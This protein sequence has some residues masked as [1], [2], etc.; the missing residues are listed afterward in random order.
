MR[1]EINSKEK[2]RTAIADCTFHPQLLQETCFK[3]DK[4][5]RNVFDKLYNEAQQKQKRQNELSVLL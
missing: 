5:R 3:K 2:E 1:I 4:K